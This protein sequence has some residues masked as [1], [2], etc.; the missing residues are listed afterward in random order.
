MTFI[1]RRATCT[2]KPGESALKSLTRENG[3][4]GMKPLERLE[5]EWCRLQNATGATSCT[6]C[7]AQLDVK[8]LI[9]DSGWREAP[10]VRDMTKVQFGSS[11]CQVEGEIVPAFEVNL[12]ADESVYFEHHVLLWKE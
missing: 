8:N 10:R 6:A 11:T 12:G 5:C 3:N 9:S 2:C 1:W 7:G 4:L